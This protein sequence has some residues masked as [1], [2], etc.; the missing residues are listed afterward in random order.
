MEETRETPQKSTVALGFRNSPA[1]QEATVSA[2]RTKMPQSHRL[3][4]IGA[5]LSLRGCCK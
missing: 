2:N 5:N 1:I 4:E 3:A